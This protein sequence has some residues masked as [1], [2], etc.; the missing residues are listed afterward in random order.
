M[1][2]HERPATRGG[3]TTAQKGEALS[4]FKSGVSR[5]FHRTRSRRV[6]LTELTEAQ[7]LEL[8][9]AWGILL[10][11]S[12]PS[13]EPTILSALLLTQSLWCYVD[14]LEGILRGIVDFLPD[15]LHTQ[16]KYR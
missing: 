10:Q 9:E 14:F 15:C 13:S 4:A 5:N 3:G 1:S 8:E 2:G 6:V 7:R 16:R 12:R 11:I